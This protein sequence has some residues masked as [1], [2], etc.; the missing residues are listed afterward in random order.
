MT[1]QPGDLACARARVLIEA[2]VDGDLARTDPDLAARMKVHLADCDDCRKQYQQAVSL[3]FRLKALR[4]PQPPPSLLTNVMHAVRPERGE[5]RRAW[6]LLI[7][8][9][10]L[11]AF[12]VWYLS[13]LDGLASV[14]SGTVSDLQVLLNWGVG[15]A[16]PPS[17][18]VA[19]VFLL[20]ALIALAI[21]AA[22]HLAILSR[23]S[24]PTLREHRR[25]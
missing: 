2:Y 4:A 18:P 23:L 17:I 25:A 22:Y 7:P 21:T 16:Q 11:V 13:G 10:A 14:A 5:S 12:I 3:P 24:A 6:A 1:D 9:A 19:D 15:A 8:E 20:A